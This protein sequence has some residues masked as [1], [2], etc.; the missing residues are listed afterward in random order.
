ML[1]LHTAISVWWFL[2]KNGITTVSH[3]SY[4]PDLALYDFFL[5]SRMKGKLFADI[6][7]VKKNDGGTGRHH[8]R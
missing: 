5:F 4:S 6:D 7:E 1:L 8:K 2:T 3:S